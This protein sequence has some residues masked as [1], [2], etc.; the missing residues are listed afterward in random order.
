[1]FKKYRQQHSCQAASVEMPSA[2]GTYVQHRVSY[3]MSGSSKTAV[4]EMTIQRQPCI[5]TKSNVVQ[6]QVNRTSPGLTQVPSNTK[7]SGCFL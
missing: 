1:M 6:V 2:V 3:A 5:P 7:L 4:Y